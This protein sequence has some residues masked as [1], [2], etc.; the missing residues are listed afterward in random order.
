MSLILSMEID[1]RHNIF[2]T[3]PLPQSPQ[4]GTIIP[5]RQSLP[6][7]VQDKTSTDQ[8][9]MSKRHM[10]TITNPKSFPN[11]QKYWTLTSLKS[12]IPFF[13]RILWRTTFMQNFLTSWIWINWCLLNS[14]KPSTKSNYRF[15]NLITYL[16]NSS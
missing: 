3:S 16:K 15:S 1:N 7:C 6:G 8:V 11:T 4:M 2:S 13:L 9:L 12:L 14:A 10:I 5:K